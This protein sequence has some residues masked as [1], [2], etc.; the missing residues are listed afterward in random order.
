MMLGLAGCSSSDDS[1]DGGV[2]GGDDGTDGGSGEADIEFTE[3]E[4]NGTGIQVNS[5]A[6]YDAI[7]VE[8]EHLDGGF[9]INYESDV[10]SLYLSDSGMSSHGDVCF[11]ESYDAE[12]MDGILDP[13]RASQIEPDST[14]KVFGLADGEKTLIDSR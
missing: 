13:S 4:T 12:C 6:G 14:I 10:P 3:D 1:N 9:Q 2:D 5:M 7:W 11:K 8:A